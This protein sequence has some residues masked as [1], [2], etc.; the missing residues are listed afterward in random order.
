VKEIRIL[1]ADDHNVM[2]S[3]LKLLLVSHPGFKVVSEASDGHQA[4]EN[5]MTTR[6]DVAVLDIAMPN[7]SGIEAIRVISANLP[8]LRASTFFNPPVR[9]RTVQP[10]LYV[11][12][13]FFTRTRETGEGRFIIVG[14]TAHGAG[15]ICLTDSSG[16]PEK[17]AGLLR[18]IAD[19]IQPETFFSLGN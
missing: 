8:T 9:P 19:G 4:V 11:G 5:A 12:S 10:F 17:I 14:F 2:R 16:T 3:G 7:L 13:P 6:P 18:Q 15:S 1:L